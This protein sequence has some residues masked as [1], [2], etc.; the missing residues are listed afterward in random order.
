MVNE[1]KRN[2]ERVRRAL[3]WIFGSVA[4]VCGVMTWIAWPYV[5]AEPGPA[6]AVEAL[7]RLNAL[8]L[9]G[10]PEGENGWDELRRFF[11]QECGITAQGEPGNE[12]WAA[13]KAA[14]YDMDALSG[15]P[16]DDPRLDELK[17]QLETW[18]WVLPA[19]DRAAAAPRFAIPFRIDGDSLTDEADDTEG[20][21][22][23][24]RSGPA[25]LRPIFAVNLS[26]MRAATERGDFDEAAR[27]CETSIA[28]SEGVMRHPAMIDC[29]LGLAHQ[30]SALQELCYSLNE[31]DWPAAHCDELIGAISEGVSWKSRLEVIPAREMAATWTFVG[32]MFSE[33]GVFLMWK[34]D[35]MRGDMEGIFS[36][37]SGKAPGD[38]PSL[39]ERLGNLRAI[40]APRREELEESWEEAKV[41]CVKAMRGEPFRDGESVFGEGLTLPDSV[42]D[43]IFLEP[44]SFR[45]FGR[46]LQRVEAHAA[47]TQVMLRLEMF[48]A[49]TGRWPKALTDAM[50]EE[51]ATDP[52]SGSL[53]DY[54]LTPDEARP[55]AMRFPEGAKYISKREE[56]DRYDPFDVNQVRPRV[57]LRSEYEAAEHAGDV[58]APA[59]E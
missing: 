8:T 46:Q 43:L 4:L 45:E 53:F 42:R 34:Y 15:S 39:L 31:H 40:A 20:V 44:R 57:L 23:P 5:M 35:R 3:M 1:K 59:G 11:R 54:K 16:W 17:G 28:L 47:A 29:V 21:V 56:G 13:L 49:E 30:G 18:L 26:E 27:R 9:E 12:R 38:P 41:E 36:G 33:G 14:Q 22:S 7:D 25:L 50:S 55:Y 19:M 2:H 24:M 58:T 48:H 32:P 37:G 52:V 6:R 51:Q 10:Q